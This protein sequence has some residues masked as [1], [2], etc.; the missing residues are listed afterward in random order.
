MKKIFL[1]T[2]TLLSIQ[3]FA[4]DALKMGNKIVGG[5]LSFSM[6]DSENDRPYNY[7]YYRTDFRESTDFS[8]SPYYGRLYDDN[9]MIG[10]RLNINNRRSQYERTSESD[11]DK[12]SLESSSIGFGGFI[13]KYFPTTDKFGFFIESGIDISRGTL[14]SDD[15]NF[16][17]QDS[18]FVLV[19]HNQQKR[20]SY[21]ASIDAEG[22]MYFF[23]IPR[24]SIET[25]FLQFILSY[26]DSNSEYENLIDNQIEEGDGNSANVRFNL[27]NSF[28]FDKIFTLNYYF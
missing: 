4:Q 19:R 20:T 23:L 14:N 17:L 1:L 3:S 21:S 13:R 12:G 26:S 5:G 11:F 10:I 2:L 8:F 7:Y 22:G 16:N 15:Q 18:V 25:N 28:S 9:T 6:N 24:L 27:I